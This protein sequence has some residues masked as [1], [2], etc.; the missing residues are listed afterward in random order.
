MRKSSWIVLAIVLGLG[1][2]LTYQRLSSPLPS[3]EA[4]IAALLADGERAIERRS[5]RDALA[6]VS[7]EYTDPAGFNRD[8]LRLQVIEAFRASDG[9]DVSLRTEG[10]SIAGDT[11]DVRSVVTIASLQRGERREV[12]DGPVTIRLKSESA[13]RYLVFPAKSWKVV[14]MSGLPIGGE[15]L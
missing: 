6:C 7:S 1:A 3:D 10:I 5:I 13:R 2:V 9:Y 15:T 8:G 11:A 12:F 4:Q 14:G